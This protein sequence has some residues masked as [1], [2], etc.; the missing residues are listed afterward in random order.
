[1]Q[2]FFFPMCCDVDHFLE[3]NCRHSS[4][5]HSHPLLTAHLS[6]WTEFENI[7]SESQWLLH[8]WF[9][10]LPQLL[11]NVWLE[12]PSLVL[13]LF[14]LSEYWPGV[15]LVLKVKKKSIKTI[16][17]SNLSIKLRRVK[18]YRHKMFKSLCPLDKFCK[19]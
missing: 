8:F 1:M 14:I 7:F 12:D 16:S 19:K 17:V 18:Q 9:V 6:E 13:M 3:E 15:R 11:E 10:C 4:L 2:C 5:L